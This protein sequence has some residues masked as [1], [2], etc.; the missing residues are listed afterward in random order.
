M[1][2]LEITKEEREAIKKLQDEAT[3]KHFDRKNE[4]KKGVQSK[5]VEEKEKPTK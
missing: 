2:L 5:K 4:L 3:K 1:A